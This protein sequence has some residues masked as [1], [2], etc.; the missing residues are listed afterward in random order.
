MFHFKICISKTVNFMFRRLPSFCLILI[1][2]KGLNR[3]DLPRQKAMVCG[4]VTWVRTLGHRWQKY[5]PTGSESPEQK[6]TG[7]GRARAGPNPYIQITPGRLGLSPPP[8]YPL[9]VGF[10]LGW[11][12]FYR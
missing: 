5:I 2:L 9:C 7:P 3:C 8:G 11:D 6:S 10:V 1:F 12:L 4:I